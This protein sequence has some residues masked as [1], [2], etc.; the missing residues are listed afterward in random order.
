MKVIRIQRSY[1]SS[2]DMT[3]DLADFKSED[4]QGSEH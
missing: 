1:S 4:G 2:I 3:S